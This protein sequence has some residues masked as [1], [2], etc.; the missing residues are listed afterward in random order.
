VA[1]QSTENAEARA[2]FD[3]GNRAFER[4]QRA[5]GARRERLLAEALEAYVA[6]LAVVRSKNAL[7]N[8][9]VVLATLGRSAEAFV[10]FEEYL[11]LPGLLADEVTAAREQQERLRPAIA[12][13]RVVSQPAGAEVRVDRVDLRPI[14]HTPRVVP[15]MPGP[16]QLH[17]RAEH[18]APA[19]V[20]VVAEAGTAP[21]ANV[22]LTPLPILLTVQVELEDSEREQ[23]LAITIDGEAVPLGVGTE[24]M[25]GSHELVA[26]TAD[27]RRAI[28]NVE[29]AL[30]S[31]PLTLTLELPPSTP[32]AQTTAPITTTTSPAQDPARAVDLDPH[33]DDTREDDTRR[34]PRPRPGL[35]A[36]T[37]VGSFGLGVAAAAYAG[38]ARTFRDRHDELAL[39]DGTPLAEREALAR[40]V[41]SDQRHAARVSK[42]LTAVT[43]AVTVSAVLLT[44]RGRRARRAAR[45]GSTDGTG[46]TD[47]TDNADRSTSQAS[48]RRLRL[49][50]NLDPPSSPGLVVLVEGSLP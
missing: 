43:A 48:D 29:V 42:V 50:T 46:S 28:R 4:S 31:E 8:A 23:P 13:L 36:A 25:P 22:T 12:L 27:G 19:S 20:S 40:L 39:D 18:Y 1:A 11:A 49:Q 45:A 33:L 41:Y 37:W 9:G 24:V 3:Q 5:A 34:H 44:W 15:L 30:G 26:R 6:S 7:F 2:F 38:R 47:R 35:Q 10:Y 14:G 17:V 21:D 32:P 16:H